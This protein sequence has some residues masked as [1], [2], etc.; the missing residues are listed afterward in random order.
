MEE[1][2]Q[3]EGEV[4]ERESEAKTRNTKEGRVRRVSGKEGVK[5]KGESPKIEK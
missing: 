4:Q 5:G 1:G 2:G 3:A